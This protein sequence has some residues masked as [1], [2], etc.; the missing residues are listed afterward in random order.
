MIRDTATR[1]ARWS[2]IALGFS[3]P[4]STALDNVLIAV[5]LLACLASGKFRET[6][7]DLKSNSIGMAALVLAGVVILGVIWSPSP[8]HGIPE[9]A[10]Y[11]L[12]LA[13]LPL[14]MTVFKD[15][16]TRHRAI[17]AFLAATVLI[18]LISYLLW[19]GL[20]EH[21]PQI[22]GDRADPVVFKLHITHNFFMAIAVLFFV[23]RA[24]RAQAQM[25]R[26][27]YVLAVFAAFNVLFMI[28]GRIGPLVLVA[29]SFFFACSLYRWR[30]VVVIMAVGLIVAGITWITPNSAMHLRTAEA[31]REARGFHDEGIA[32]T[33]V[34]LRLDF[35]RNA[36]KMI[37]HRPLLGA[38]TG[39]FKTRYAEEVVGTTAVVPAHPH[40][41]FLFI[42]AE[43]GFVGLAAL[44]ALLAIQW[45][46]ARRMPHALDK[47]GA[48]A[49]LLMFIIGGLVSATFT[50]HAEALFF[51]W[52]SGVLWSGIVSVERGQ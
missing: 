46:S 40:N 50:D 43:L 34:G 48:R 35:Y 24:G 39:G 9:A 4:V 29:A 20:V 7:A 11:A 49:I 6:A 16:T 37:A 3:L 44:L 33:S 42:T 26:L 21:L 15:E 38:G 36:L 45:T 13:T 47:I 27:Y 41:T 30:G 32:D 10:V 23:L 14:F 18:L 2:A 51:V 12:K 52:V 22:K 17:S 31:W 1:A 5:F 19:A 8:A 28:Q 25:K